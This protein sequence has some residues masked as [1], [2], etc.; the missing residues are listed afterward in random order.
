MLIQTLTLTLTLFQ[1]SPRKM[2]FIYLRIFAEMMLFIFFRGETVSQFYNFIAKNHDQ[3]TTSKSIRLNIFRRITS[4][5][6]LKIWINYKT[7]LWLKLIFLLYFKVVF[8]QNV[9]TKVSS[10]Y[11]LKSWLSRWRYSSECVLSYIILHRYFIYFK[12]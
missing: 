1:F 12:I 7:K 11:W 10:C 5:W 4:S 6:K 8:R 9:S 3:P 2:I